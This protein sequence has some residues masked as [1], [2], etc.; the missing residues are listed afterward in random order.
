MD[1]IEHHEY[2]GLF[3]AAGEDTVA[4]MADDIRQRGLL[5]PI[6]LLDGRILDGRCRHAACALAGVEPVFTEYTGTNPLCDAISWN[7]H[8]RHMSESQRAMVAATIANM[9]A[10]RPASGRE[11]L[12]ICRVSLPGAAAQMNVSERLVHSARTLR[13]ESPELSARV[14]R[15]HITIGAALRELDESKAAACATGGV[16]IQRANEAIACLLRIPVGDPLRQ[17]GMDNV[18]RWITYNR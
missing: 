15:G 9:P 18:I 8:R 11:T 6:V 7:V 12:Q 3:P 4:M 1:M 2:A 14:E 16:G 13:R 17:A 5:N 10:G